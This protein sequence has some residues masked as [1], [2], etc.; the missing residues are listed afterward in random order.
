[1]A[2]DGGVATCMW[3]T[4]ASHGAVNVDTNMKRKGQQSKGGRGG[5]KSKKGA[6]PAKKAKISDEAFDWGDNNTHVASDSDASDDESAKAKAKAADNTDDEEDPFANETADDKRVRLAKTY[7]GTLA[8]KFQ[9]E[10]DEDDEG[11]DPNGG[12]RMAAQLARDVAE[13]SGKLFKL[14]ADEFA[15]FEFDADSSKFLKGHKMPVTAVC[16]SEDGR[17]IYSAAKDGSILKWVV[18]PD[19][20]TKTKLVIPAGD[21]DD[22]AEAGASKKGKKAVPDHKKTVLAL[23]LSS[24]GKYLASGGVDKLLRV[25]DGETNEC[26]ESFKGHRDSISSLAFRKK[27]HMLF[28]GSY[29]RTVKHWNLTEMGYVETLFGHQNEITAI[30]CL[31]KDRVVS[32]GRDSSLRLWKIP[33]ETQLVFHG[34][35]S[36]DCVAMVNDDYYVTGDDAGTLSLWFN[37]KKK[38]TS[39]KRAAHGGKWISSIAVLPRTDLVAT[40][41]NDGFVRLWKANLKERSLDAVGAIPVD[42]FVNA[43][44]FPKDGQFLVAGVGKEHRCGRWQV[45]KDAKNGVVLIALPHVDAL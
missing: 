22:E 11:A 19:G 7:L 44:A 3:T 28:S 41:A 24:D 34:A 23:A 6:A 1:M 25:W 21:D 8:S 39:V 26:L 38:P 42:G 31:Q 14:V 2:L 45:Q 29:D 4:M 16:A 12:D 33:E 18:G 15:A 37:G 10:D 17:A 35:G 43:L 36:I 32:V 9:D 40:G 20:V 30:G 27:A 5:Y 13:S